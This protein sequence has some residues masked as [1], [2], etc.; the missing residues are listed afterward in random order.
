MT[1]PG[2][3]GATELTFGPMFPIKYQIHIWLVLP[4]VKI[5]QIRLPL[6]ISYINYSKSEENNGKIDKPNITI[7]LPV[8]K[9]PV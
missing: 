1:K 2:K 4:Q 7:Y 5:C 9:L 8:K 6:R 3:R